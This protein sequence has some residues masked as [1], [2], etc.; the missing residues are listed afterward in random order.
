MTTEQ[1]KE[2]LLERI[3]NENLCFGEFLYTIKRGQESD[4][5]SF[6]QYIK[7]ISEKYGVE[8]EVRAFPFFGWCGIADGFEEIAPFSDSATLWISVKRKCV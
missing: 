3:S 8:T 1:V 2:D 5:S 4:F 7:E 6:C